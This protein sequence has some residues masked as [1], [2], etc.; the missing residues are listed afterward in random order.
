MPEL[1]RTQI[2]IVKD[3]AQHCEGR[4]CLW[5]KEHGL[6]L[7]I[8]FTEGG[9]PENP[10]KFSRTTGET[11]YNIFTASRILVSLSLP[12]FV[13][14][15][16]GSQGFLLRDARSFSPGSPVFKNVLYMY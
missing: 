6:G 16:A 1:R 9:K 7:G 4:R 13:G 3:A 11:K 15:N 12:C 8:D 2:K 14:F 5:S 10:D